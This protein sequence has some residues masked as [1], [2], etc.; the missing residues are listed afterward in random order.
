MT[1]SLCCTAEIAQHRKT[2]IFFKKKKSFSELWDSV[3]QS[4][5]VAV[6]EE[7]RKEERTV[8]KNL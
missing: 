3:S 4:D 5:T 2:I 6:L 8:Q 7:K 1:R